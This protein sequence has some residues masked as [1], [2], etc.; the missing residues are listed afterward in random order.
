VLSEKLKFEDPAT[1][2]LLSDLHHAFKARQGYSQMEIARKRNAL[3]NVLVPESLS[4]HR[5]R[6]LVSGFSQV[7]VWLQCFN[8]ASLLAIR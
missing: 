4:T 3:E 6:L 1:D 2:L 7:T 8:F 5:H